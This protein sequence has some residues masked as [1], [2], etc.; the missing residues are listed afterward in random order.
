[1]QPLRAVKAQHAP[2]DSPWSVQTRLRILC[3]EWA[4]GLLCQWTPKPANRWRLWVLRWFGARI[5]GRPFVHQRARIQIPWNLTLHPDC[6]IGDRANLYSL[7][8]IEVGEGA[9]IAQ[10]AYL[11]SGTHAFDD[12]AMPLRIGDI[13]IGAFAF[14]GAR[15]FILPGIE[16]GPRAIV[17]AGSVVVHDV[18]EGDRVA[19]NP[20]RSIARR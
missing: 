5:F 6:A 1:M 9:T 7:A 17:G 13:C 2:Q 3:W 16:I 19:G 14:V 10:E 15:A 11:C 4:W 18:P 12:P 20:A 8:R